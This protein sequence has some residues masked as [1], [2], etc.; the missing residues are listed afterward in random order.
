VFEAAFQYRNPYIHTAEDTLEKID[1]KHVIE[2]GK[3]ILG[4]IYELGFSKGDV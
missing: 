1:P 4:Y 3:L 2:H